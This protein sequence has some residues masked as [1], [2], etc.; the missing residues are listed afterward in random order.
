MFDVTFPDIGSTNYIIQITPEDC[1]GN[2]PDNGG[3][4]YDDPTVGYIA[5][6]ISST[7]FRIRAGDNDNGT[8]NLDLADLGFMFTIIRLP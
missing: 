1:G 4:G 5:S 8:T 6:T 7:G 3:S 2:C